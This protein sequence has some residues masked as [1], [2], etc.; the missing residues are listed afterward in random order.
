LDDTDNQNPDPGLIA[1]PQVQGFNA[2]TW[3]DI[4]DSV[5]DRAQTKERRTTVG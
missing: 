4:E 3:L 5:L 1:A 2:G